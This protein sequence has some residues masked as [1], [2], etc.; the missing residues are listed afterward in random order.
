MRRRRIAGAIAVGRVT[1]GD[2]ACVAIGA[3]I[4]NDRTI[5]EGAKQPPRLAVMAAARDPAKA[6]RRSL[7]QRPDFNR[8]SVI[9]H[10]Y[11]LPVAGVEQLLRV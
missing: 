6:K 4:L 11:E 5:G 8:P 10:C 2:R 9:W 3:V 7:P 1:A